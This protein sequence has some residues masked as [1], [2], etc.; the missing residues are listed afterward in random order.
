M[1]RDS[2]KTWQAL[3]RISEEAHNATSIEDFVATIREILSDLIKARNFF[4]G[5][6][7]EQ[8]GKYFFPYFEDEFDKVETTFASLYYDESLESNMYDL[9]G[10]LTDYVRR[11]G[12]PIRFPSK[13]LEEMEKKGEIGIFGTR[14]TSLLGIPLKLSG[15]STGVM[16]VQ[17]YGEAEAYTERDEELMIFVSDHIARAIENVRNEQQMRRQ[18]ELLRKQAE[19]ITDSIR[20]ARRIQKTVLPSSAWMDNILPAYFVY[21]QPKDILSGDFYWVRRREG[22]QV[23]LVADCTGHGVPGAM[24]SM[25]GVTL[26]NEQIRTL[27]VREPSEM[28]GHLRSKVKDI[29]L[30]E[31]SD[32]DQK[33]GMDMSLIL[34]NP[35]ENILKFAGANRP[36][37]LIREKSSKKEGKLEPYLVTETRDHALYMLRGDRQPIGVYWD[38]KPFTDHRIRLRDGDC[39]Y[40]FTDGFV[41]QYGGTHRKKFK[42]RNFQN[43]LLS[44]QGEAM[45]IQKELLQEAFETWMGA[46]EQIDD[47]TVLG[48]RI[49]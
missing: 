37:L 8:S 22:Y 21:Y 14:P 47:V 25:L 24:M 35:E 48:I 3:L 4:I 23:V 28:L 40:M 39:L 15:N 20:Y 42:M 44:V 31:S 36:L 45:S 26:L 38:E 11:T 29:L 13:E 12:N 30:Q 32:A 17:C 43:L 41:D 27:W 6:Y 46:N 2:D 19:A 7:D 1:Q 10:T 9:S 49:S 16:V 33:E 34:I 5:L 18:H